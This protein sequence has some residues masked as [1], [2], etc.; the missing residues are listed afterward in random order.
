MCVLFSFVQGDSTI[1]YFEL[2]GEKLI[3][4]NMYQSTTSGR[5]LGSMPKRHLDYMKCE[6]M[7]FYKLHNGKAFVEPISMTVPRKVCALLPLFVVCVS[8]CE[9]VCVFCAPT[10]TCT[11]IHACVEALAQERKCLLMISKSYQVKC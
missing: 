4:L 3:F 6:V 10:C 1:K 2:A 9:C 8:V 5:G 7:R 11:Y